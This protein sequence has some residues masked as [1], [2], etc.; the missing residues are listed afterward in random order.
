M[1]IAE[2]L[3]YVFPEPNRFQRAVQA[4]VSTRPGAWVLSKALPATDRAVARL[5][6]GRSSVSELVAGVPIVVL[7]TT[8]RK[9]GLP[10]ESQLVGIPLRDAIAVL[11]TNYGQ[12]AT[13]A[14]VLNLEAEPR[15][16]LAHET[17]SIEVLARPATDA[18]RGQV[19]ARTATIYGGYAKYLGRI[20]RR[21]VR[22]FVLESR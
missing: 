21:R 12:A 1:G 18:E 3:D 4:I 14:W 11:G 13:P 10:R 15:A 9:S 7:T 8:G 5:T 16:T 6:G 20:S 22:I 2:D 19:L 17:R